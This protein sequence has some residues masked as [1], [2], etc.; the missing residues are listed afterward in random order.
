[1]RR[2]VVFVFLLTLIAS[3]AAQAAGSPWSGRWRRAAGEYGAGS[4]V[5]TLV[6]RGNHVTG[7]YHW[8]GCT[9]VFGGTVTGT[10]NGKSLTA[11]FSHH[12]DASGT[13]SLHLSKNGHAISGTFKVTAGTCKGAAGAFDATY[14]GPLRA[15]G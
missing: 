8:K 1:M 3:T 5:F 10:A 11:V 7:S 14:V 15:A 4:G 12:G 13:L 6:Q 2:V 9:N